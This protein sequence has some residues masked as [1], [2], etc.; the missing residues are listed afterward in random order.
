MHIHYHIHHHLSGQQLEPLLLVRLTMVD[1]VRDVRLE[2]AEGVHRAGPRQLGKPSLLVDL[3]PPLV[4]GGLLGVAV[5]HAVG[6]EVI[7]SHDTSHIITY[8]NLNLQAVDEEVIQVV[9]LA[10]SDE[11]VQLIVARMEEH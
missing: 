8:H 9:P 11:N 3:V 7:S 6:E 10:L 2:V 1:A 4:D 5:V